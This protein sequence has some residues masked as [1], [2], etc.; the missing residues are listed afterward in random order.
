MIRSPITHCPLP[1]IRKVAIVGATLRGC[2]RL[3]AYGARAT[4]QG[5]PYDGSDFDT[6]LRKWIR[7]IYAVSEPCYTFVK[8]PACAIGL[9]IRGKIDM[10]TMPAARQ[11]LKHVYH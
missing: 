2:P 4:T 8:W 10:S 1:L 9:A 11:G 3:G 7:D 5:C 6:A